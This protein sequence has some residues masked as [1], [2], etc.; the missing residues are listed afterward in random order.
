MLKPEEI[1]EPLAVF[2]YRPVKR[3]I[4]VCAHRQ[5]DTIPYSS[6]TI[7]QLD[8]DG[9]P[10]PW[11]GN[12]TEIEIENLRDA[13][14]TMHEAGVILQAPPEI[15][16]E[17][18]R[19]QPLAWITIDALATSNRRRARADALAAAEADEIGKYKR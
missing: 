11:D 17:D 15:L 1:G 10:I 14:N 19:P 6:F 12:I 8:G 5:G 3:R 4:C 2:A 13:L 7:A 9:K 16:V 18:D